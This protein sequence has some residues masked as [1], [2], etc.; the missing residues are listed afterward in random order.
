MTPEVNKISQRNV[1]INGMNVHYKSAGSGELAII[2]LHG[3]GIDSDKYAET[4]K[5]LI[6]QSKNFNLRTK[7][8]IPDLPGFGKSDEPREN[9]NLDNY[10]DFIDKFIETAMRGRGFELIKNIMK[11]IN[12][13]DM[14]A[15]ILS[16][17]KKV[18]PPQKVILVG[19]SF[20]GRIAI[21]YATR[22]PDKIEKLI[23][24]G[25]AGIKHPLNL[26]QKIF[27][28]MAKIGK[29]FFSLPGINKLDKYAKMFL[30]GAARER[31]Y[32]NAN[33]GMKEIM[34]CIIGE[35]LTPILDRVKIPTLLVWGRND[36]STPLSDGNTMHDKIDGSE[37][38]IIDQANH[39]LPYQK[40][41]EFAEAVLTFIKKEA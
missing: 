9:W 2:I 19:H 38:I 34:K 4:A 14:G 6:I 37:M 39:S 35:D 10:V 27:Y 12:L 16:V 17:N 23:L 7:I 22:H 24:T 8:I 33:P 28:A 3:W 18:N 26:R 30:Y 1:Q 40:P 20:G 36:H 32:I 11:N 29:A 41:E 25:A 15:G 13:N 21:K 5:N 31:D